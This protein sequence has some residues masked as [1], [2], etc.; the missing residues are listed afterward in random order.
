MKLTMAEV[1]KLTIIFWLHN[2]H[3]AEQV[4]NRHFIR[5]T[6][7]QGTRVIVSRRR[8]ELLVRECLVKGLFTQ[9]ARV[10]IS[11]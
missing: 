2:M 10:G 1:S 11:L 5:L 9:S 6:T 3:I 8:G 4:N 7:R